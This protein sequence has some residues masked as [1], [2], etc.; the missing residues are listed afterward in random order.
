MLDTDATDSGLG[1][2]LSQDQDGQERVIAYAARA[3]S[4]AERNYSTTR[5]EPL[6]LV[7]GSGHFETFLYGRRFLARTDHNALRW[8]RNFKGPRGQVARWLERL[9]DFDFE[10]QHLGC[11]T[12]LMDCL[13]SR[14]TSKGLS[15]VKWRVRLR[16]SSL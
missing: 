12:M 5:K 1:A 15:S 7:R 2:V 11:I 6:A 3:L 4:K 16:G 13:A 14:G 8:L 9:S 10:V